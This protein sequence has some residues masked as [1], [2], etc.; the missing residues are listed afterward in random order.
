MESSYV[1]TKLTKWKSHLNK[2]QMPIFHII[3]NSQNRAQGVR[4]G[5]V[6]YPM[7]IQVLSENLS[8]SKQIFKLQRRNKV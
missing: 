6:C 1:K 8:I 4:D 3:G 7:S 5:V 2:R